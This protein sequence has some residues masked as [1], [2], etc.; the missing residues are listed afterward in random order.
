MSSRPEGIS[1]VCRLLI[2]NRSKIQKALDLGCGAGKY[3]V[4]MRFYLEP[5]V[6]E[7][8]KTI[9]GLDIYPRYI[10]D[11]S[12]FY[13]NLIKGNMLT[14]E[15]K[16][17]DLILF[18]HALEH[19]SKEEGKELILRLLKYNKSLIV[20]TPDGYV[21]Q[22]VIDN[23]IYTAHLSGWTKKDFVLLGFN[24]KKERGVLIAYSKDLKSFS[25]PL[26]RKI[27]PLSVRKKLLFISRKTRVLF[28]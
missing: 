14:I 6:L 25:Y 3:G 26:R 15:I 18:S 12:I 11:R 4:L 19:I 21:P 16:D 1:Y 28:D 23:N 20:V 27:L 5:S 13:D 24:V 22:K 2:E 17:Y 7:R 10:G 9:D 8:K